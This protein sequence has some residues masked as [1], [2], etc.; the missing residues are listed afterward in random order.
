MQALDGVLLIDKPEGMTSHDVVN[1]VRRKLGVRRVGHAG[2][3]DPMATGLLMICVG[4]VTRL[5]EYLGDGDKAYG[6]TVV[7]GLGTDTDDAEGAVVAQ[8]SALHLDV[9]KV[10]EAASQL[11]GEIRQ[12]PPQYSAVHV[13]GRRAYDLARQGKKVE[14]PERTVH[15]QAFQ[16]DDLRHEGDLALARFHVRCSKGT[17]V[18]AL[19]RDLGALLGVP[20]HMRS[21]RRLAIGCA[22]VED[23]VPLD[24]WLASN[25]PASHLRD[26]LL[27]LEG[28]PMWRPARDALERLA[29]GQAVELGQALSVSPG[30]LVL[31]IYAGTVAAVGEV[32]DGEPTMVRPKKVFW[33]RG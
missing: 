19:C 30:A 7:F 13:D 4:R 26:P 11:T 1:H 10:R 25:D 8:A 28:L 14:L 32:A 23:A 2:T 3:L 6:G 9:A 29:N 33:K 20:A 21:L 5:L 31:V 15:V 22:R 18:R 12:R 27:Y 16:I 17:Y 24:D